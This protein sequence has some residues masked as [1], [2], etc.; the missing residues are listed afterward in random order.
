MT[1]N[2]QK[3]RE[4]AVNDIL[5]WAQEMDAFWTLTAPAANRRKALEEMSDDE[6]RKEWRWARRQKRA[7]DRAQACPQNKESA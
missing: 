4:Q 3:G 2:Q 1:A 7:F 6:L 5:A